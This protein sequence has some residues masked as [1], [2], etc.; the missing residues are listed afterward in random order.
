MSRDHAAELTKNLTVAK[1]I[2]AAAI[3]DVADLQHDFKVTF[4]NISIDGEV[5]ARR[6]LRSTGTSNVQSQYQIEGAKPTTVVKVHELALAVEGAA[7]ANGIE[8]A[9][10]KVVSQIVLGHD[11]D[12]HRSTEAW[13]AAALPAQ[14]QDS[15]PVAIVV[16]VLSVCL[17]IL[18]STGG[19]TYWC[20]KFNK[21]DL[22]ENAVPMGKED[23]SPEDNAALDLEDAIPM[24][25][26]DPSP[27]DNAALDL[28]GVML[29]DLL[30]IVGSPEGP[31]LQ[32][33]ARVADEF[34][35]ERLDLLTAAADREEVIEINIK[36]SPRLIKL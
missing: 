3:A 27:E 34:G 7:K 21:S 33:D 25:K 16:C 1:I 36:H 17:L 35:V 26:E 12:E 11:G 24:G 18:C 28:E 8:V 31:G 13:P 22:S 9:V 14:D 10:E 2:L 20:L 5:K 15:S 6:L 30:P 29:S 4:A 32:A 23:L 19:L